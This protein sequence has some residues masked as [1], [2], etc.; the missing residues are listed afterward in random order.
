MQRKRTILFLL[1]TLFLAG[2]ASKG[3]FPG[4]ERQR[5]LGSWGA[6]AASGGL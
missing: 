5:L 3:A 2:C 1:L 6:A 4:L